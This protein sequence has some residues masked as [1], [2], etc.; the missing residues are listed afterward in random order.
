VLKV[1]VLRY[2]IG[3]DEAILYI[4]DGSGCLVCT[5]GLLALPTDQLRQDPCPYKE[6]LSALRL[7]VT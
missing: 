6:Q 7:H 3:F 4:G 1:F 2:T 5:R